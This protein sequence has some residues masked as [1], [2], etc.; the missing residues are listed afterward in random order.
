[1]ERWFDEKHNGNDSDRP[2]A[3]ISDVLQ[4]IYE[5]FRESRTNVSD[6]NL[7]RMERRLGK[8]IFS[9]GRIGEFSPSLNLSIISEMYFLVI[10]GRKIS[11]RSM[12]NYEVA[13]RKYNRRADV[14]L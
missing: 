8:D 13:L 5:Q 9:F 10:C 3:S 2:R 6:A 4:V 7:D 11:E 14:E 1:M 12:R